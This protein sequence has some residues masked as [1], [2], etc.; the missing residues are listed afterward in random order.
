MS[1]SD[2]VNCGY[3][4]SKLTVIKNKPMTYHTCPRCGQKLP[5]PITVGPQQEGQQK[6][7]ERK[8]LVEGR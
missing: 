5:E 6:P 1:A 8:T 4:F 7:I 2:C 3:P